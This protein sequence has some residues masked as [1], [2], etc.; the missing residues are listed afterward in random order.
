MFKLYCWSGSTDKIYKPVA[1]KI[2][3]QISTYLDNL[4]N[5]YRLKTNIS[6]ML[7][8]KALYTKVIIF[9][10]V[11]WCLQGT[12]RSLCKTKWKNLLR[13]L[14]LFQ[15]YTARAMQKLHDQLLQKAWHKAESFASSTFP[16]PLTRSGLSCISTHAPAGLGYS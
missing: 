13:Q 11:V 5:S 10:C 4:A 7:I 8:C 3:Y 16:K 15:S 12:K 9:I 14:M 6:G 2:I 1:A